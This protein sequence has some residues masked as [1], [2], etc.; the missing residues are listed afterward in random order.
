M[1]EWIEGVCMVLGE[2]GRELVRGT[3]FLLTRRRVDGGASRKYQYVASWSWAVQQAS[4]RAS[5]RAGTV[6]NNSIQFNL[7]FRMCSNKVNKSE[8][9]PHLARVQ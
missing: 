3:T 9:N 2:R 7:Q 6:G 4:E 5:E 8:H 1:D